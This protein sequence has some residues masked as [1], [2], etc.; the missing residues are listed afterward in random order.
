LDHAET[1][2]PGSGM[3][4]PRGKPGLGTDKNS[5]LIELSGISRAYDA[6]RVSAVV[7]VSLSVWRGEFLAVI[8]PSGSGKTTLLHLMSGMDRPSAGTVRFGGRE[9][10]GVRDWAQL[11]ARAIGF[12]FQAFHLLPTL[13]AWENVQIPMFGVEGNARRRSERA[14]ALL[15]QTGLAHRRDHRPG[16]LSAGERQRVA[17]ARSLANAPQVIL[18]DEPTGNLDSASAADVLKLLDDLRREHALT[19]VVVTHNPDVARRADRVGT[20]MDG[21][22]VRM[23]GGAR[24]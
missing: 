13:S 20:L 6:G 12:V 17:I 4:D 21:R 9:P 22:I 3:T 19:L 24:C 1:N 18:A 10:A 14:A 5:P 7:D 23:E 2:F 15:A 8:G 16:E 11:R